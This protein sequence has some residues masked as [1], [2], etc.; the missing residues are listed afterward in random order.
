MWIFC[1][2]DPFPSTLD[3]SSNCP[4]LCPCILFAST[5]PFDHGIFSSIRA[6]QTT[7]RWRALCKT[8]T[9]KEGT[10]T[11]LTTSL[12]NQTGKLRAKTARTPRRICA[13][14]RRVGRSLTRVQTPV[15][16]RAD[17]WSLTCRPP[18]VPPGPRVPGVDLTR[19]TI[20]R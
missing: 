1:P 17:V 13:P 2:L 19:T 9:I 8:L 12:T 14:P 11:I 7:Q 3:L 6:N 4:Y 15:C 18:S 20:M 10:T 5:I 16:H